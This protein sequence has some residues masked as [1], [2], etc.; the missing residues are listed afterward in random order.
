MLGVVIALGV[1]VLTFGVYLLAPE[2]SATEHIDQALAFKE[3]GD[4]ESAVVELQAT[5]LQDPNNIDAR[6]LL[7]ELHLQQRNGADA[8]GQLKR[9]QELGVSGREF[10]DRWIS[11]LLMDRQYD[12]ALARLAFM[13]PTANDSSV[14]I[15]RGRARLGLGRFDEAREAFEEALRITPDNPDARI[16]LAI[17]AFGLDNVEEAQ[18]LVEEGLEQDPQNYLGWMLKG[19]IAMSLYNAT[20]AQTAFERALET[21]GSDLPARLAIVQALLVQEKFEQASADLGVLLEENPRNPGLLLLSAQNE[22]TGNNNIDAAEEALAIALNRSPEDTSCLLLMGWVMLMKGDL[23][24]AL[25]N[26]NAHQVLLPADPAGAKLLAFVLQRRGELLR[27]IEVLQRAVDKS[28]GDIELV[29][30]LGNAYLQ[31]GEQEKANPYFSQAVAMAPNSALMRTRWATSLLATGDARGALEQLEAAVAAD[32]DY[33]RAGFLLARLYYQLADYEKMQ[34][35]TTVLA[36]RYP[37]DPRPYVLMAALS[38]VAADRDA[39]A[40]YYQRSVDVDPENILGRYNLARLALEQGDVEIARERF[41]SV[42]LVAPGHLPSV[43]A[44]AQILLDTGHPADALA[45]LEQA[46]AENTGSFS[47]QLELADMYGRMGRDEDAL[48][49]AQEAAE[50]AP[51]HPDA[52]LVLGRAQLRA[53]KVDAAR[54]T[55]RNL[56]LQAPDSADAHFEMAKLQLREQ[57]P[58]GARNSLDRALQLAPGRVDIKVVQAE[59]LLAQGDAEAALGIARE[60]QQALPDS[61]QGYLLAGDVLMAQQQPQAAI[62]EYEAAVARSAARGPMV[63]LQAAHRSQGNAPKADIL[64]RNWLSTHTDDVPIRIMLAT[65]MMQAGDLQLAEREYIQA[66]KYQPDNAIL[67]NNLAWLYSQTA[68]SR[69]QEHAKR[70]LELLPDNPNVLDTY[71]WILAQGES[72]HQGLSLLEKAIERAPGDPL[73]R[74]HLAGTLALIGQP[75]QARRELE[76]ILESKQTTMDTQVIE[77]AIR[78]LQ[79]A[80][81]ASEG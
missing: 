12:K 33:A 76:Y 54:G 41:H 80:T 19:E 1:S 67:H 42:L 59:M 27:G 16:G 7:S 68:D 58:L 70:A 29:S 72:P 78:D 52:R 50:L 44:L 65:S 34:A 74:Y 20:A 73:I 3:Q 66:L 30:M 17:T 25:E 22:L 77:Q 4:L 60:I 15:L 75:Y 31:A 46:R 39:A 14:L 53:D 24:S 55:L 71:G 18:R 2:P 11:A 49:A 45:L 56:V 26:L 23:E 69:A 37:Q 10:N 32:P 21:V 63:K 36:E 57:E 47:L 5:L 43:V 40:A 28:P 8:L 35:L 61:E 62:A 64:L 81:P 9:V 13:A 6:W 51:Y 79:E 48:L 38:E